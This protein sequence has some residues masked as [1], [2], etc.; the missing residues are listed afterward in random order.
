[1]RLNEMI[2][3][4]QSYLEY[5]ERI[6]K[7]MPYRII[8]ENLR[9]CEV[10]VDHILREK[11]HRLIYFVDVSEY[12]NHLIVRVDTGRPSID[13]LNQ[14]DNYCKEFKEL[15]LEN[16][17]DINIS[18]VLGNVKRDKYFYSTTY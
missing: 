12:F 8:Q 9:K 10:V 6:P 13:D 11:C 15:F 18:F 3:D 17:I 16:G 14:F 5:N 4:T 2:S 1:M 7:E